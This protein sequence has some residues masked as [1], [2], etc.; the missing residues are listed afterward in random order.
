[1]VAG[2]LVQ[3]CLGP[4]DKNRRISSLADGGAGDSADSCC[5]HLEK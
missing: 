3:F 2:A 1:M 4:E 5:L